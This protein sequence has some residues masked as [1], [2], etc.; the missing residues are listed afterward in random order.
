MNE[1]HAPQVKTWHDRHVA[2]LGLG[3]RMAD[4]IASEMGSWHFII[5]Q[6]II[7]IGWMLLNLTAYAN[8]WDPYPFILLNLLF[9]TQAAYAAPV[10]MMAQN[11]QAERDRAQALDDYITNK[12]AKE[13]IENLQRMLYRIE[14]EKLDKLIEMMKHVRHMK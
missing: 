9:S 3:Q 1:S 7:V 8:H 10:I 4:A 13:E 11:R 5:W 6:T 14:N 2:K 12:E